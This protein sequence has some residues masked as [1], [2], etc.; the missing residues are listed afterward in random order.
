M[1][2]LEYRVGD[3]IHVDRC[4][5]LVRRDVDGTVVE[6][7]PESDMPYGVDVDGLYL[8]AH[9]WR[10]PTTI[11]E[12]EHMGSMEQ[13]TR[14]AIESE[15]TD[16]DPRGSGRAQ[17]QLDRLLD[18]FRDAVLSGPDVTEHGAWEP[19]GEALEKQLRNLAVS[20]DD[21][22]GDEDGISILVRWLNESA[23]WLEESIA[24]RIAETLRVKREYSLAESVDPWTRGA[25]KDNWPCW[26]RGSDGTPV[27]YRWVKD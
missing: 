10:G 7:F 4:V 24:H 9:S 16:M 17:A 12:E 21:W 11:Q 19:V 26:V 27:P 25:D 23:E 1:R 15:F 2:Q 22:D 3:R 14:D 20:P 18:Q 13:D 8:R 5:R 6:V